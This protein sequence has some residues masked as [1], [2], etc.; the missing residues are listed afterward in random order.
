VLDPVEAD[1]EVETS[2]PPHERPDEP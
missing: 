1:P 2:E